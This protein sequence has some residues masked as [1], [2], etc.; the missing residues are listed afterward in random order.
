MAV[1]LSSLAN[2]AGVGADQAGNAASSAGVAAAQKDKQAHLLMQWQASAAEYGLHSLSLTNNLSSISSLLGANMG[3]LMNLGLAAAA[4]AGEQGSQRQHGNARGND[5]NAVRDRNGSTGAGASHNQQGAAEMGRSTNIGISD[6]HNTTTPGIEYGS[7]NPDP[8][9][10][11]EGRSGSGLIA[12]LLRPHGISGH[13]RGSLLSN[14]VSVPVSMSA[15][16]ALRTD[17]GGAA[18]ERGGVAGK[19]Q[20]SSGQVDRAGSKG[21]APAQVGWYLGKAMVSCSACIYMSC[22]TV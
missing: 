8:Y 10:T 18:A 16:M 1:P 3:G 15:G 2:L 14:P 6:F 12:A 9:S 11:L 20:P 17:A 4:T 21:H 5:G 19:L 7:D 22:M 13:G